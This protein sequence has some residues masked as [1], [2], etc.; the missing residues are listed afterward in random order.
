MPNNDQLAKIKLKNFP[1]FA[2]R[3][4]GQIYQQLLVENKPDAEY[5]F[6]DVPI[7]DF[8]NSV[9][10]LGYYHKDN[11][12]IDN[13]R[14]PE[15]LVKLSDFIPTIDKNN[16]W[17]ICGLDTQVQ[18]TGSDGTDGINGQNGNGIYSIVV[19]YM[20][21]NDYTPDGTEQTGSEGHYTAWEDSIDDIQLINWKYLWVRLLITY[22]N[23]TSSTV[24]FP[25][26]ENGSDGVSI[27]SINKTSTS[28]NIDT[29]TITLSNNTTSTFTVTN[30]TQ[31]PTGATGA[32]G[33]QGPQGPQGTPG[34]HSTF[35]Y[36]TAERKNAGTNPDVSYSLVPGTVN[37]YDMSF[38]IPVGRD[39]TKFSVH[40]YS[41]TS[42][43]WISETIGNVNC[44]TTT[45]PLSSLT[46]N[47]SLLPEG[48]VFNLDRDVMDFYYDEEDDVN[49]TR[50]VENLNN[51]INAKFVAVV[52]NTSSPSLI[53]LVVMN[54]ANFDPEITY[55]FKFKLY[56]DVLV[57]GE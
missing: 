10:L 54:P 1:L 29:Y 37:E 44:K 4:D 45:I 32:T 23:G 56:F 51:C 57:T 6:N 21:T 30:G 40:K 49:T 27:V 14:Y 2:Y 36:I 34:T 19:S 8:I 24:V 43:G 13:K 48:Y 26:G 47:P 7:N 39:G 18:A 50:G 42:A 3:N 12:T 16:H 46:P 55:R 31:G 11:V 35:R 53:K 25:T 38:K 52:D 5:E 9:K 28:G 20:G 41:T 17:V 15:I 33:P 22:T